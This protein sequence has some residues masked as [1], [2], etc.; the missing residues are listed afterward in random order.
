MLE[1]NKNLVRFDYEEI[2][3]KKN[4]DAIE[5]IFTGDTLFR[6]PNMP[7][8]RGYEGRRQLVLA[9]YKAFP[10][11][12][13]TIQDLIAEGD[14]VVAHWSVTGTHKGEWLGVK[15]AGRTL[16][17]SGISIFRITEGKIAEELVQF[18]ALGQLQQLSPPPSPRRSK[19][20]PKPKAKPKKKAKVAKSKP[21][22][23]AKKRTRR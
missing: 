20:K 14:K 7:E 4:L 2:L 16:S 10:D 11:V 3:N 17:G 6:A 8:A 23:K 18:D 9:I 13:Y 22:P 5:Q 12:C 19:P 1:E 15:P 21:A